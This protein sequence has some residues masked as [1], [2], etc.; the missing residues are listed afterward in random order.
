MNPEESLILIDDEF[1]RTS[2][3]VQDRLQMIFDLMN[4]MILTKE[5]VIKLLG[6]E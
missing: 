5:Q 2:L 4:A 6:V 3:V 1:C